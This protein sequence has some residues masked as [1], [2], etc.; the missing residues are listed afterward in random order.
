MTVSVQIPYNSYIG[1]ASITLFSF[2]F[3]LVADD[4]LLVL[5]NQV[6]QI[7]DSDY[8]ISQSAGIPE[9]DI[10]ENGGDVNFVNPPAAGSDVLILRSTAITQQLDYTQ[11]PFP[12]ASHEDE[13]D[14]LTY[15]LQE[16][17]DGVLEGLTFDLSTL[18]D[19]I[20]VLIVNSGGTDALIPTWVSNV[21]AGVFQGEIAESTPA[22]GE[23]T[24]KPDG[25]TWYQ[26]DP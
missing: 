21:S 7:I 23:A 17:R 10:Y 18:I 6:Q 14:K 19:E 15:I 13:L 26:V 22:D 5:V 20:S 16:L 3:S 4:D 11:A 1:N 8:T 25:F 2:T 24:I 9:S 12:S